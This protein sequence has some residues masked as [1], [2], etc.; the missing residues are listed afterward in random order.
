MHRLVYKRSTQIIANKKPNQQKLTE[1]LMES[2]LALSWIH[3][4][5]NDY[6]TKIQEASPLNSHVRCQS[7]KTLA[8]TSSNTQQKGVTE[9]LTYHTAYS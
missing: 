9:R 2:L 7:C 8:S 4:T 3:N 5:F 1:S 6:E